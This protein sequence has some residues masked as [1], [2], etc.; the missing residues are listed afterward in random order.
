MPAIPDMPTPSH[1]MSA[2][3]CACPPNIHQCSSET[4]QQPTV[5]PR[6][7]T[8]ILQCPMQPG[9]SFPI[10]PTTS[11][12]DSMYQ[13]ITFLNSILGSGALVERVDKLVP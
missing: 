4:A 10:A 7:H 1:R 5:G 11:N 13:L 2:D 12:N 8:E 6:N 9:V 3:T